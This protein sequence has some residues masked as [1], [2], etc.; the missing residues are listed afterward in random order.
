MAAPLPK[1]DKVKIL[2]YLRQQDLSDLTG[3]KIKELVKGDLGID[4]SQPT[5]SKLKGEILED[6]S[7]D[8]EFSEDDFSLSEETGTMTELT[9]P[10]KIRQL[11]QE[12]MNAIDYLLKGQSDRAA[13]EAVGVN[14]QTIWD[15]R[16]NDPL[17]IAE[18]NRQRVEHWSEARER[19]KSLA[20]RAL[21]VVEQQLNSDDPRAALAAAK[22]VLQGTRLLGDTDLPVKGPTTPEEVLLPELRREARQEWEAKNGKQHQTLDFRYDPDLLETDRRE[23]EIEA[24]AKSKLKKA[25]AEAGLA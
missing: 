5:A 21:D 22:Y 17:F 6:N 1:E 19:L 13:A 11:S 12:Q 9:N 15:W 4:I 23:T 8:E 20:N 24:L 7:D 14:R 25:M 2:D 16:N 3:V 10:D 18:L